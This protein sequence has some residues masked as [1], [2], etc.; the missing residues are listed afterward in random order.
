MYAKNTLLILGTNAY[1]FNIYRCDILPGSTFA[2]D[3][4]QLWCG[5][6]LLESSYV[7]SRSLKSITQKLKETTNERQNVP[8]DGVICLSE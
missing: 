4:T 2:V 1:L 5:Q 6:I 8:K 3:T 7:K